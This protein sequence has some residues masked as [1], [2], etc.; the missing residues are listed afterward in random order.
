MKQYF[1]ISVYYIILWSLYYLQ[2]TLY[3]EGSV[4][5]QAILAFIFLYSIYC[6]YKVVVFYKLPF[7]FKIINLFL[8][9]MTTYGLLLMVDSQPI[10]IGFDL[11]N[12]AS[13]TNFL[14]N[15]YISMLP[16]YV[17]YYFSKKNILTENVVR[18]I[19]II[20][21]ITYILL[22]ERVEQT[23]KLELL[24]N[25]LDDENVVNNMSYHFLK[26]FPLLFFW[27][28]KPFI[29]FVLASVL[30]IFIVSGMKRGAIVIGAICLLWFMYSVLKNS[31]PKQKSYILLLFM[32][33]IVAGYFYVQKMYD[34][35]AFF[36]YRVEQTIAG[37]SSARDIIYYT[38]WEHFLHET[39]LMR[40]LFGNGAIYTLNI[41]GVYAHNDWLELLTN[42]GLLGILVY[43]LFFFSF[44]YTIYKNKD[45]R[46]F[47]SVMGMSFVII[48]ISSFFSMSYDAIGLAPTIAIGYC[49]NQIKSKSYE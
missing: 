14:K 17:M 6:F 34:S 28:K 44:A 5:S 13:K 11:S 16:I 1:N 2:G 24:A 38:L 30:F 19:F 7:F 21:L 9:V 12:P 46:L 29:Q 35:N 37:D 42:Q 3:A 32:L 20:L 47:V 39:S 26:L 22:F 36:Q 40:I 23:E 25:N 41:V 33:F 8:L 15:I 43:M 31:S 45:N 27:N 4:I 10:Y 48:F 49:M 18:F